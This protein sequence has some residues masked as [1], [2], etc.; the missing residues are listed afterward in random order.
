VVHAFLNLS[1]S[2]G[3]RL[4][5]FETWSKQNNQFF[6]GKYADA[7]ALVPLLI[8]TVLLYLV[9]REKLLKPRSD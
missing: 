9:G 8:L 6:E 1:E 4:T 3:A 7:L 5:G 2:I